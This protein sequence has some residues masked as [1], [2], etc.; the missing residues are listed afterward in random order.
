MKKRGNSFI[1]PAS[2]L[3]RLLAFVIDLIIIN[4]IIFMPFERLLAKIIPQ[5]LSFIQTYEYIQTNPKL[6]NILS[7]LSIITGILI[8]L[9]FSIFEWKIQQTPGKMLMKIYI[10]P[11][12]GKQL[13]LMN[14]IISNLTFIPV[15]PFILLWIID[16][17]YLITSKK[18]QRLMEKLT[19]ILTIEKYTVK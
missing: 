7:I 12:H 18:N 2:L 6:I 14:Y 1:A 4:F 8:V 9:Y 15:F 17:I 16:P 11:E 5:N 3:K 10:I 13:R 19:R